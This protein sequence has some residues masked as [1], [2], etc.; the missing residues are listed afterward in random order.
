[1][2]YPPIFALLFVYS[3]F[4]SRIPKQFWFITGGLIVSGIF[5][6]V[7]P[8]KNVNYIQIFHI[9]VLIE[10]IRLMIAG[11][12]RKEDGAWIIV[13][14]FAFLIVFSSY[15]PLM[16]F[17]V[18]EAINGI[19][20]GYPF[21]F[22]GLIISMSVYLSRN[23]ARTNKNLEAQLVQVKDL[24]EKTIRQERERARL[25]AENARKTHELEEARQL[26]VSMLP[27]ELPQLA[28][29]EIG[30]FMKTATEVGGDYYDFHLADNGTLTVA[31]GDAT[32]HGMKA[33]TMVSVIKSLFIAEASQTDIL[34]FFKKCSKT[35][36][37][38]H[39]GNLYMAM[40]LIKIKDHKM[41]ASSA[42]IP[43]IYLYRSETNSVEEIVIK[44]MPLG[45]PA[46]FP[47]KQR[48][49]NLTPGDTVLLM[50][51]GFPELFNDKDEMLDYPR[52]KEIFKEAAD[53][54]ADEIIAHLN[55]AGERW[56]NGRPQDDDIT[57]VVLK[58]KQNG[59]L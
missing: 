55:E 22:I 12:R 25:E 28:Y 4:E 5:A 52:V 19:Y 33:G 42:G 49:T 20:N 43:P 39:L 14:G 53:R 16:D 57:F 56:S 10:A 40:M 30:V 51:D 45:G 35:I 34:T 9:A 13:G 26:Q 7:E 46:S 59:K 2:P 32:G 47:Y 6:I 27:K 29:L 1:M 41:I 38:M 50:S 44:G 3:L 24:S 23:F 58:V 36:K 11:I 48:E 37:H 8:V 17:G 31:V 21:G 18:I 15:D 54:S